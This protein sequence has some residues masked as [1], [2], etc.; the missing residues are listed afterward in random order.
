MDGHGVQCPVPGRLKEV[1][2]TTQEESATDT[3]PQ[4]RVAP[5]EEE[6]TDKPHHAGHI[7]PV[8]GSLY[9]PGEACG[10]EVWFLYDTGATCSLIS[11][12][13]WEAIPEGR[14]PC[15]EPP[16]LHL[17]SIEGTPLEVYGAYTVC[18]TLDG[19]PVV[20]RFQVATIAEEAILGTDLLSRYRAQ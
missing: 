13:F 11:S 15:L 19:I 17:R 3:V 20:A 12:L 16:D 18:A 5:P 4:M 9:V 6:W 10:Q 7:G 14:R 1:S 2:R 8:D